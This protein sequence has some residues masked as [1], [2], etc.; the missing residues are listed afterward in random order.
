MHSNPVYLD[1]NFKSNRPLNKTIYNLPYTQMVLQTKEKLQSIQRRQKAR[2]NRLS[3]LNATEN[4]WKEEIGKIES[5]N[6]T[7]SP[8][9]STRGESSYADKIQESKTLAFTTT[10]QNG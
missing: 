8:R 7:V 6:D 9:N 5:R 3:P 4:V 2:S 10:G 1:N